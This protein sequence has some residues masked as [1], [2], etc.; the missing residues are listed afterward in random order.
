MSVNS[1]RPFLP[2]RLALR[3]AD[4][5]A[6]QPAGHRVEAGGQNKNVQVVLARRCLDPAA[7]HS[8]D[9]RGTEINKTHIWLIEDLI[10]VLFQGRSL[11]AVGMNRLRGREYLG[12]G[13]IIDPRPCLSRQN[14]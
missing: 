4:I 11:D 12:N 1:L 10:K 13:R 2:Q 3:A 8:L 14:L 7:G 5:D 6:G 9:W